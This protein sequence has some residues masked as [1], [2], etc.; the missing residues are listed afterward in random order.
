MTEWKAVPGFPNYEATSTGL[1]RS[2]ARQVRNRNGESLRPEKLMKPTLNRHGRA[3][4]CL[5]TEDGFTRTISPQRLIYIT[6]LGSIPDGYGV[7]LVDNDKCASVD[8]IELTWRGHRVIAEAKKTA[9]KQ[10]TYKLE[11]FDPLM[12]YFLR[13]RYT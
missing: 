3:R 10:P 12:G 6:F 13:M 5:G 7:V 11:G 1:V 2:V 8:N 9:P 4:Y